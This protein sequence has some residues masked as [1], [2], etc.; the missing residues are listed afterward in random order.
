[1]TGSLLW[2]SPPTPAVLSAGEVHVW[3]ADEIGEHNR[4]PRGNHLATISLDERVRADR[5]Y[6]ANDRERYVAARALLRV[7]VGRYL[8][9]P[10]SDVRFDYGWHGKP[11]LPKP[12]GGTRDLRFN[13]SH[14][15]GLVLLAFAWGRELGIDIECERPMADWK[16]IAATCFSIHERAKLE[17]LS[18]AE[19]DHVFFKY[20]TRKEAFIKATGD[21]LSA[22]LDRLDVSLAP[23]A[24]ARILDVGQT[25]EMKRWW[26][27]DLYPAAGFAAAIATEGQPTRITCW[28]YGNPP[29]V[30]RDPSS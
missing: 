30:S 10:P 3:L 24:P 23:G 9:T 16:G 26:L 25:D 5:F 15:G 20:W 8:G 2:T 13:V 17:R 4:Y 14:S 7:L 29:E 18:P 6:F 27:E 12:E 21:G 11:S 22:Q 28:R 19:R 1:M